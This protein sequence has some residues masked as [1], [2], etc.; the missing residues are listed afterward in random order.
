[1]PDLNDALDAIKTAQGKAMQDTNDLN[2]SFTQPN[3]PTTGLQA[4]DLEAPSKKFYPV[5]TPLRNSISRVTNGFATQAN[6]RVITSINVNNQRA[7]VSEGR[8]GG[9]IQHKTEDY[10]ASFRGWGLENSVTWEADYAAK[11]FEDVKAL[12]VQQ[13]LEATMIEEERLIIGGNTSL[14]MGTTPTPTLM[15]VGTGG[16]LAA[17][18]WSVIC[19]ALGPQA[20]LDVVGVNNGGIG[21]QFDA[22]SKVPSKI[23]R[24]N[25]DGTTEEFGGGSAR[26]STAATVA[27]TG[28]TSS[29]TATVTPVIGAVGYAWYI[30]AAGSERLVAVSTVNSVILKQAADPNAQLASTLVD[31]DNSTSTI[32][33]DG[34]LIQAFKPNNNAYVKVMPTGTAGVGTTLTS[35]GAG[36][37]VEFEEAFEYFYRKYRLSPDVIYVSTQEL[38]TITSLIIKNGGAPL[39]HLNVDANNPASLQAGVVIGSYQN[40]ITGQRVP[41]RIHPNLA[42][43]TIFM[44]TSRLPYPLANVGNIVQMKMRRDYHQIE[45]PLRTRR[46]EYGVYADGVLQH[47]APFSMGIITNIAKPVQS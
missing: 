25:A 38:L 18:T 41:L 31:E 39:L 1:M 17:Q 12:A 32:D 11:N 28:T 5:L 2:K 4:Y 35:D 45:W 43:G 46:Y 15:A 34:L 24:T 3:G 23:T 33:F 19:V 44:F 26:K 20:Y 36:G 16:T 6:W 10:F 22:S 37:I 30:G 14:A 8:R 13:T 7:G 42:A 27:T 47:Y 21:Q 29:I 9:V 40:K